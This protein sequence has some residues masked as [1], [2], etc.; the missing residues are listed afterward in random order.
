MRLRNKAQIE[1]IKR[2]AMSYYLLENVMVRMR[3]GIGLATDIYLPDAPDSG[4]QW[5]VVIERTPYNKSAHSRSE[6]RKDGHK[7]SRIEMAEA[8]TA[9]GFVLVFQDCRGRYRSEGEFVKYTR[10]AEDGFDTYHWLAQQAW[11]NGNIGSMGLS[12][13]AHTQLA[14]ACLNPPNLRTMVLDS[15]GFHNAYQCGI[16]QGGA[17]ELKQATWAFKQAALSPEAN[18]NPLIKRAFEQENIK[19]W[20]AQ[21]PWKRGHSPLRH[22]PEY[23]AYLFTQWQ[24]GAFDAYWQQLGLYAQGWYAQ[25]PDIPVLFMS[26]W[27]DAYVP[28]T[29]ANFQAFAQTP[30]QAPQKLIMGS[31]LHGD[32]NIT[33]SGD[34]E[35][36]S[37]AAFDDNLDTTWLDARLDWFNTHLKP[38]FTPN[39]ATK[40]PA[41]QISLFVMGGGDGRKNEAGKLQHGGQWLHDT[42]YPLPNSTRQTWYLQHDFSLKPTIAETAIH[43]FQ[44]DPNRPVPT[45]GG[46]ITSG[47]PVFVG[48]A[49][50]QREL[51]EFFGS[52]GHSLPLSARADVLSFQT[53]V[54]TEDLILA[55]E[56]E[57]EL[58][59]SS[60]APDCDFTA[61]LIDVYPPNPDYPQGYAMNISDGIIRTRYRNAWEAPELLKTG[62]IVNVRIRP[63]ESCNRFVKGH[64]LRLD[65]AG[66]NFPHFD[67]NPNSGEPEGEAQHKRIANNQIFTGHAY[68]SRLILRILTP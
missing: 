5:P 53:D 30:R 36:G 32:R 35:F 55:G 3:D 51:P 43:R 29:L 60:D 10:E 37:A 23:E 57:V 48:G 15:G 64:R 16:R 17:F 59:I 40:A 20:F 41:H 9:C 11:C 14:A 8:F 62:E 28:A 27:Y 12:Y 2:K 39:S 18:A 21:M 22:L 4:R 58:W 54:L 61:K 6:I 38:P 56:I 19:D 24:A 31:W 45:I 68:P 34:V 26:S 13:A 7:I 1:A 50:D 25:L 46:A 67:C 66:S 52:A 47:A 42:H 33:H 63:F 44:A 65:I 49:F